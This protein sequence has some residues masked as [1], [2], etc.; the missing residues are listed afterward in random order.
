[1]YQIFCLFKQELNFRFINSHIYIYTFILIFIPK[2]MKVVD[3][4]M[5]SL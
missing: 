2:V 5:Q 3:I 1:M 4:K